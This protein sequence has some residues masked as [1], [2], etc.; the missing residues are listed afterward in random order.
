V[1]ER[2]FLLVAAIA[3]T[4]VGVVWL[5]SAT[6]QADA[7]QIAERPPQQLSA[8]QVARA[9]SLFERARA[10]NPDTGPIV[11]E[12]GLLERRGQH[13]RALALLR[14]VVRDEPDNLTAWVLVAVAARPVDPDLATR[15]VQRA[16]ALNPLSAQA[17]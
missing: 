12:A 13:R 8:A 5:H 15:A 16:R 1:V 3:A 14:P 7:Q 6:L 2:A 10:D 4:V 17:R 11:L 9:V